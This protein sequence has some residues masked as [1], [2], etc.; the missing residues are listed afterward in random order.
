VDYAELS[1]ARAAGAET[2]THLLRL[3]DQREESVKP[4]VVELGVRECRD[5]L[6]VRLDRDSP[7]PAEGI[8]LHH[9]G[10][11]R[12]TLPADS[13]ACRSLPTPLLRHYLRSKQQAFA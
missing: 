4:G 13:C 5:S 7:T 1:T 11:P 8:L 6:P 10:T 12:P 9:G 3:S 2:A